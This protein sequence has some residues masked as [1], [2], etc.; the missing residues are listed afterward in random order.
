VLPPIR[1]RQEEA[2]AEHVAKNDPLTSGGFET[3]CAHYGEHRLAH[4]GA[5]APPLY[6]TSNFVY[7]D[8]EAFERR[9]LRQSPYYDY[10]RVGNPT[11]AVLEAKLAVLEHGTW[12]R[13]FASGMGAIT[14]AINACVESGA[15]VVA[16]ANCYPPTHEYLEQYLTR[17]GVTT[18]FVHGTQPSDLLA[19]VQ[20][21]TRLIYLESPTFGLNEILPIEPIASAARQRGIVTVFD[22]SWATPYF[23][24]PLDFG[25][26]LV[27]HSA[28]KYIG[29]HSDVVAGVVVGRDEDLRRRVCREAE[30][31]GATLDPFAAWLLLR[32]L[33]TL[34]VRMEQHQRSGLEMA[35]FLAGHSKVAQV[36]HPGL[37]SHPQHALA[38]TQL[39]GF[40][41]L[42][43]FALHD[44]SRE[45]T[46]RFLNRLRLFSLAVSWGGYESLA[47]GGTFFDRHAS[48]ARW[49]IRL[50]V[51]LE[52]TAD[53]LNDVRQALED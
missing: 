49:L 42:F 36:Y 22:N 21:N 28:T 44:Q 48:N 8:A 5:V 9:L 38:R 35:R 2:V 30:L 33:R 17:F 11:T 45:A 13:G 27:V 18:T 19:A 39:R 29:G 51:G 46:H 25:V 37:E 14:A 50:H 7:P 6:Q 41:S 23:Q 20:D 3:Q 43:S 53:L 4:G 15:H 40:A 1:R 32:G 31:H 52:T 24:C 12:A 10:T 16:V 47:T 26:D 34:A